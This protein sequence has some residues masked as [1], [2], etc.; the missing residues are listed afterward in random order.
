M[1]RRGWGYTA[2]AAIIGGA[3]VVWALRI[4]LSPTAVVGFANGLF[5]CN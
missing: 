3:V 2:A 5:W 1:T 4:Y